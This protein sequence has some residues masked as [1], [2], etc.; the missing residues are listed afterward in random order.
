LAP[1]SGVAIARTFANKIKKNMPVSSIAQI[2]IRLYALKI[3]LGALASFGGMLTMLN[4]PA[5]VGWNLILLLFPNL[6]MITSGVA[7]WIVAPWL[8]RVLT[9]KGNGELTLGGLTREDLFTAV[10][11]ALG[12]YFIMDSFSNVFGWVHYFAINRTEGGFHLGD[13]PS[14]Y[15]L[16]ERVLTLIAGIALSITCRTWG[17]RLAPKSSGE[18][19]AT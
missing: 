7:L 13:E 2:F 14:Y 15:D 12:V 11:L 1:A 17:R 3:L 18:Q 10:L 6:I 9:S 8:S 4:N 16:T 5:Y 19:A